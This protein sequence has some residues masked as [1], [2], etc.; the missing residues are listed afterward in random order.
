MRKRETSN[1][2]KEEEI[3]EKEKQSVKNQSSRRRR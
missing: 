3:V 2:H 1:E